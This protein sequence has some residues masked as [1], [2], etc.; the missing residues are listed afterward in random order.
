MRRFTKATEYKKTS[1]YFSPVDLEILM[2]TYSACE[3]RNRFIL[4]SLNAMD[5]SFHMCT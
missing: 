5:S 3:E 2:P 1:A 4:K